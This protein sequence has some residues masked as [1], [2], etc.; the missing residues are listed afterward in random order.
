VAERPEPDRLGTHL[1]VF[2]SRR[3]LKQWDDERSHRSLVQVD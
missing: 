3:R 1:G 2:D